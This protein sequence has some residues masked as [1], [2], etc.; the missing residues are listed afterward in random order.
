MT[1]PGRDCVNVLL[2]VFSHTHTG[3]IHRMYIQRWKMSSYNTFST[4]NPTSWLCR[5][6]PL[7][8]ISVWYHNSSVLRPL[9][10]LRVR[11]TSSSSPGRT[12]P[13]ITKYLSCH[14]VRY[15]TEA[16]TMFL[17]IPG[18]TLKLKRTWH[19]SSRIS[20]GYPHDHGWM[21]WTLNTPSC[22]K[23]ASS[24]HRMCKKSSSVGCWCQRDSQKWIRMGRWSGE[25]RC[26]PRV[27]VQAQVIVTMSF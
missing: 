7:L 8:Y 12:V 13:K 6:Q 9:L 5:V 18:E 2:W 25:R 17:T 27:V 19:P 20:W 1:S 16:T 10:H 15:Q 3:E 14:S 21:L 22:V 4:P 24:A 26:T 23:N 11:G